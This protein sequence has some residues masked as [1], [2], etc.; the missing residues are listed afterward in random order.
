MPT[1]LKGRNLGFYFP[2]GFLQSRMLYMHHIGF[3]QVLW[4]SRA[5]NLGNGNH[6]PDR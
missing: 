4:P 3:L 5:L 2:V 6:L 1:N